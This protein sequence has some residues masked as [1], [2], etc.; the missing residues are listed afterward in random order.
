MQRRGVGATY[1]LRGTRS[2]IVRQA[3]AVARIAHEDSRFD[4]GEG[5]AGE[6]GAAAAT[7]GIIHDLA[8]LCHD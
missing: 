5:V 6:L 8:A 3:G 1:A 2:D 4:G 7:H